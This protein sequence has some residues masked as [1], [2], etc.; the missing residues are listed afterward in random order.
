MRKTSRSVSVL[1]HSFS[2]SL[3]H[4]FSHSLVHSFSRSLVHSISHSLVHSY[5]RSL[6]QLFTRSLVHSISHSLVLT[7]TH[8]ITYFLLAVP[9]EI[10][11]ART[12]F[13]R[14]SIAA[15]DVHVTAGARLVVAIRM[16][17]TGSD[18]RRLSV[19][20]R[21]RDTPPNDFD[22]HKEYCISHRRKIA[23]LPECRVQL[24]IILLENYANNASQT[25]KYI[26]ML[27]ATP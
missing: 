12:V 2:R 4:S 7:F 5:T 24:N 3:V 14:D 6:F 8:P 10:S 11:W 17:D 27:R 18:A 23:L 19:P 25:Y 21:N 15:R 1:V 9:H 26:F 16:T 13:V 20:C 22:N